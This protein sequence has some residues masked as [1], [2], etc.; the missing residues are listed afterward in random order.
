MKNK[1][2]KIFI[3]TGIYPP[4]IGGP[5]TYAE[6]LARE[7]PKRGLDVKVLPFREV[8]S[9]P[10]IIR[11]LVYLI[12][13]IV[14]SKDCDIIFSQDPVSTG[15]PS[16]LAGFLTGKKIVLRIAGD[17]AWEQSVQK[18]G[19]KDDIDDFQN[20]KYGFKIECLRKIQSF[21]VRNADAVIAPSK[22]FA[23]LVSGWNN[24]KKEI[25]H[26]YNGI[27][28]N[29]EFHK[30]DKYTTNTII[31]AARL[32]PWKGIDTLIDI[33]STVENWNLKIAGEGPDKSRLE[34]MV[35]DKNLSSRV[36]FLGQLDKKNL[37]KEIYKSNI[38]ALLSNFESFS[39][40]VVEAMFVGT[41]VIATNIGNLDEI[42][43]N[44]HNGFLIN[45]QNKKKFIDIIND[46]VSDQ[47]KREAIVNKAKSRSEYFSI[48][49]TIDNVMDIFNKV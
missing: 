14:D 29:F 18:Y 8:R 35:S 12:K 28:L 25:N 37:Y 4:E 5:A 11:H 46:I 47:S 20:K 39:F 38:F 34:K 36:G 49:K 7:L 33:I 3:A 2:K 40:Q 19:V 43:T 15:L 44:E 45:P 23:N 24:H 1:V 42:I 21:S 6:L 13:I 9:Y 10:K 41:P 17:Y 22:Y 32:V 26:I 48:E 30:E 27:D 16:I 31:T